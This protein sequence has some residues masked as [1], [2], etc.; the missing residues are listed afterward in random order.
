MSKHREPQEEASE[1]H[2]S[3]DF[4]LLV[5]VFLIGYGVSKMYHFLRQILKGT[6]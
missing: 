3:M 5:I 1:G 6:K 4:L 2:A